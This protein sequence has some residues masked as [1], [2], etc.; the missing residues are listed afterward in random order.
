MCFLHPHCQVKNLI[1]LPCPSPPLQTHTHTHTQS[2]G[3][4]A[5]PLS[6][7]VPNDT[8]P[9]HTHTTHTFPTQNNYESWECSVLFLA[10]VL[11]I[12]PDNPLDNIVKH[13][14]QQKKRSPPE[15]AQL[16]AGP[17]VGT[18]PLSL[19][20]LVLGSGLGAGALCAQPAA[21]PRGCR[22][23]SGRNPLLR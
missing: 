10:E 15:F 22:C 14:R 6:F 3:S 17:P 18:S 9:T 16:T 11:K 4:Q 5:L 7:C 21:V 1:C 23:R 8:P 13:E 19:Y 2:Q 12:K 20:T